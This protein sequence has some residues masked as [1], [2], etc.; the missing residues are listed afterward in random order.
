MSI[1]Q[2]VSEFVALVIQHAMHMRHIV[3][4]G[5]FASQH[6]STL[7]HKRHD[8]RKRVIED[9]M[10]VLRVSLQLLSEI[11]FI[12]RRIER[13]VVENV[14]WSK[15]EYPLILTDFN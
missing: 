10:C 9:K 7:S 14:Y 8:F 2:P 15:C 12:L 1:T 13:D 3:I 6:F 4:C 5:L 11:F